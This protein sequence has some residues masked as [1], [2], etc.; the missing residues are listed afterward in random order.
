MELYF[1]YAP[2]DLAN[3]GDRSCDQT[4][5]RLVLEG[6]HV[7]FQGNACDYVTYISLHY[8]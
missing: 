1:P 8:N 3:H 2:A 7:V 5:G 6:W 4:R